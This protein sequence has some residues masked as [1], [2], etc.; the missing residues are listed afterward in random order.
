MSRFE[1]AGER[2]FA[3][4]ISAQ[5]P[6]NQERSLEVVRAEVAEGVWGGFFEAG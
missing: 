4:S 2:L 3:I 6:A 5:S 1:Q